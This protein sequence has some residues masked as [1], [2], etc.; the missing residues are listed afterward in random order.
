MAVQEHSFSPPGYADS[1]KFSPMVPRR[2]NEV[3]RDVPE[4][5]EDDDYEPAVHFKGAHIDMPF[6]ARSAWISS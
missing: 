1:P 6:F 3:Y 2:P 4:A 5:D